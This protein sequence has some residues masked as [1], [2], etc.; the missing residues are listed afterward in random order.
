MSS[1]KLTLIPLLDSWLGRAH[2]QRAALNFFLY[3]LAGCMLM[4]SLLFLYDA[5]PDIVAMADMA[6]RLGAS[7]M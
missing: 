2:G 1:R 4:V 5:A 3:T 6:Q 7:V